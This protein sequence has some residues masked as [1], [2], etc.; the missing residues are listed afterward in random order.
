MRRVGCAAAV[1]LCGAWAGAAGAQQAPVQTVPCRGQR[2]TAIRIVSEAPSVA[3]V[4]KIP[5]VSKIAQAT[6]ATTNP[7]VI[8]RFMLLRVGDRC[9]ERRRAESERV[10]RAQ[11]FLADASVTVVPGPRGGVELDVR[12]IDEVAL[13]FSAT[14]KPKAP[15][16]TGLRMGEANAG[17]EGIY[18]VGHWWRERALRDGF[19]FRATDYQF[20]GQPYQATVV[21]AR[22]PLGGEYHV[23]VQRPFLTDLQRFAWRVQQGEAD[24]YVRFVDGSGQVHADRLGRTFGD[25]GGVARIGPPGRLALVGLSLSHEAERLGSGPILIT[26]DGVRPDPGAVLDA[27][28][29]AHSVARLNALVGYRNLRYVRAT[30][31]D[32]LRNRQDIPVGLQVGAL[33]G[34]SAPFLGSHD[35]DMLVGTDVYAGAAWSRAA[36]RFQ[37]VG[38]VR[39]SLDSTAWDGLLG[40]GRLAEYQ[41]IGK[42]QLFTTSLEWSGGWRVRVPFRVTLAG[43]EGG[44]RG[45]SEGLEQGGR[46][47]IARMEHRID[48]GP[49]L[50]GAA[51]FGLA[52]FADAGRLW[53]GDVP[54]GKTTPVRYSA[55]ISLLAAFPAQSAR[56]WRLDLAF[57]NVPGRGVRFAL[58]LSHN[59]ETTVFWREPV[60]VAMARE[61]SVPASLFDWP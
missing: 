24:D 14:I 55:G 8:E 46:R 29:T 19:A 33:V 53:A 60:D 22:N 47:A 17:G 20:L 45:M 50:D 51:D 4:R 42:S 41:K 57:P 52:V 12:T 16:L 11:P 23:R 37:A 56:M 6:H 31:F 18:A 7:N 26:P 54:Y 49:R 15:M 1:A 48:L 38:E 32:A 2:V 9:S 5:V 36:L 30:G 35:H 13:V 40:S 58:R 39:R 25:I 3:G 27:R 59:D 21:A 34:K 10:L 61:R 28:Y 44:V 43:S